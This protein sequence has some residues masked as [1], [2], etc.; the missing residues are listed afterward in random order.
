[1]IILYGIKGLLLLPKMSK[2][3]EDSTG[4]KGSFTVVLNACRFLVFCSV[5][6]RD[7]IIVLDM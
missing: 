5:T 3:H 1:M 2:D 7:F 4:C 6:K